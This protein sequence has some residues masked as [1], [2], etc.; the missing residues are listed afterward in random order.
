VSEH[1]RESSIG[2]YSITFFFGAESYDLF[3]SSATDGVV[4]QNHTPYL[5]PTLQHRLLV[6]LDACALLFSY[7]LY[8]KSILFS[9]FSR[10]ITFYYSRDITSF[11]LLLLMTGGIMG[12]ALVWSGL[13]ISGAFLPRPP[14]GGRV[15]PVSSLC[16]CRI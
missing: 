3:L 7:S 5:P 11:L 9:V 13:P 8:M 10:D 2:N 14:G 4:I 16:S 15:Q 1:E 12:S 6:G